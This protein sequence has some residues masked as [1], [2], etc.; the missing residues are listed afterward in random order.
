MV[1]FFTDYGR[2]TS[3]TEEQA[4]GPVAEHLTTQYRVTSLH[5]VNDDANVYAI[6]DGQILAVESEES[7]KLNLILRPKKQGLLKFTKIKFIIYRG[8]DRNSLLLADKIQSKET[9]HLTKK[10]W[11]SLNAINQAPS[12]EVLLIIARSEES[13]ES[14]FSLESNIKNPTEIEVNSQNIIGK[15]RK[16]HKFGIEF[17][18]ETTG[19][20][21]SVGDARKT[22][23][24]LTLEESNSFAKNKSIREKILAYLDPIVFFAMHMETGVYCK[25]Y[26]DVNKPSI[27]YSGD[28]FEKVIRKF[29][30]PDVVYI[31]IRNEQGYSMDYFGQYEQ[32]VL[33]ALPDAPNDSLNFLQHQFFWPLIQVSRKNSE[34]LFIPESNNSTK[35]LAEKSL[36]ALKFPKGDNESSLIYL[37]EGMFYSTDPRFPPQGKE[38]YIEPGINRETGWTNQPLKLKV[39]RVKAMENG[40][41]KYVPVATFIQVYYLKRRNDGNYLDYLFP[42]F[43]N[44]TVYKNDW[45]TIFRRN[46]NKKLVLHVFNGLKFLDA[47]AELGISGMV[48]IGLAFEQRDG[49]VLRVVFVAELVDCYERPPQ[50]DSLLEEPQQ[51]VLAPLTFLSKSFYNN[52]SSN[53]FT[54]LEKLEAENQQYWTNRFRVKSQEISLDIPWQLLRLVPLFDS[55]NGNFKY[56]IR[57]T[58]F[59]YLFLSVAHQQYLSMKILAASLVETELYV[60]TLVVNND[61]NM[62]TSDVPPRAYRELILEVFGYNNQASEETNLL[63]DVGAVHTDNGFL[64]STHAAA[65]IGT[66]SPVP[67]NYYKESSETLAK[68]IFESE[69]VQQARENVI[70]VSKE[71]ERYEI[72]I[73]SGIN[74]KQVGERHQGPNYNPGDTALPLGLQE[75]LNVNI[76]FTKEFYFIVHTHPYI[77]NSR[78][79][80]PLSSFDIITAGAEKIHI[81]AV[82]PK[83][84]YL[85]LVV[86]EIRASDVFNEQTNQQLLTNEIVTRLNTNGISEED[87]HREGW[88]AFVRM[89]GL[90]IGLELWEYDF[91]T[92]DDKNRTKIFN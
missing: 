37:A 24:I 23:T 51:T 12:Q 62:T 8:V 43:T 7:D 74:G 15:F 66:I 67:Y 52:V 32:K 44:L 18:I 6:C 79:E 22:Q 3:Q 38:R 47:I 29:Y 56:R 55:Y 91:D 78:I 83:K 4:Y 84:A 49:A 50:S 42:I 21:I 77:D 87:A 59:R 46:S 19:H 85:A 10:I 64:F 41:E 5:Q 13:L 40:I 2:L 61:Q 82:S 31:D 60:P 81:V 11:E 53:I 30:R 16:D 20:D 71:R 72:G 69:A 68:R 25:D 27:L 90:E 92:K 76:S 89:L 34:N 35:E 86:D 65:L 54:Y 48:R 80:N 45:K 70:Q 28:L 63:S 73:I 58:F 26:P 14:F 9:N 88:N 17:V 36:L 57:P 75:L 33:M 1:Y 39:K